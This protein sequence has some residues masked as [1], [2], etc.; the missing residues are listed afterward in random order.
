MEWNF[1]ET[2]R[3]A[4]LPEKL[5]M[6]IISLISSG[7]CHLLWNREVTDAIKQMSGLRQGDPLS[8]YIFVLCM[9]RLSH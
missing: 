8:L 7:C 5:V 9:K 2:L 4:G 3:D 1:I 6:V